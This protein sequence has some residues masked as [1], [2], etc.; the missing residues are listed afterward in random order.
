[1]RV[2]LA[3]DLDVSRRD[4]IFAFFPE[5]GSCERLVLDCS[6]A[7]SIDSSIVSLFIRYRRAFIDAGGDS[8]NIVIIARPQVR[9]IF[10]VTGMAR[11]FTILT[12]PDTGLTARG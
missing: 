8:A 6:E 4:A 11:W 2:A 12:A 5:P 1:M 9:R 7:T 3:G 10:D